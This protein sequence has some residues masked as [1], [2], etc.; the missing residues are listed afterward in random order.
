MDESHVGVVGTVLEELEI[1]LMSL[2]I[3]IC[4]DEVVGQSEHE[5]DALLGRGVKFDGLLE[6]VDGTGGF[7]LTGE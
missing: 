7:A 6:S 2:V 1:D 3:A 4:G 5:P